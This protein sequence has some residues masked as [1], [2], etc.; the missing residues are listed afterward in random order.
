M[1][2]SFFK[3]VHTHT[4]DFILINDVSHVSIHEESVESA[5]TFINHEN[6]LLSGNDAK[7]LI[8]VKDMEVCSLS[9]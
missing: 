3:V 5:L 6:F 4:N 8:I 9:E 7:L 2:D 1:A